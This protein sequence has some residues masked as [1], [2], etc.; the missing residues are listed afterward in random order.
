MGRHLEHQ[1]IAG[2]EL[3][4][5]YSFVLLFFSLNILFVPI[6]TTT[7]ADYMRNSQFLNCILPSLFLAPV[8]HSGRNRNKKPASKIGTDFPELTFGADL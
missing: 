1:C 5:P 3:N 2:D 7:N 6:S 8:F 4:A